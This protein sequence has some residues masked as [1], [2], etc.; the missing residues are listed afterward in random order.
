LDLQLPLDDVANARNF[1]LAPRLHP[2]VG[3]HLRIRQYPPRRRPPNPIDIGDRD[4]TPLLPRKVD[5]RHSRHRPSPGSSLSSFVR[6][7]TVPAQSGGR[8]GRGRSPPPRLHPP[9]EP[10]LA[11]AC[12]GGSCR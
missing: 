7:R 2:L 4:L 8:F 5:P 10:S 9:S 1:L 11:A 6:A 3:I 12:A